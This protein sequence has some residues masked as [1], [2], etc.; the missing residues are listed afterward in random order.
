[1]SD[2]KT[3]VLWV[4]LAPEDKAEIKRRATEKRFTMSSYLRQ[5]IIEHLHGVDDRGRYI[6]VTPTGREIRAIH[7]TVEDF[8][9]S[10][11]ALLD[12]IEETLERGE[13]QQGS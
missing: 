9:K 1:M 6:P 12:K 5:I 4:R 7:D 13:R 11:T 2:E 8:R 3:D 10:Y